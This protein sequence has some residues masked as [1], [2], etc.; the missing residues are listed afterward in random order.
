MIGTSRR[1]C[2]LARM[3]FDVVNTA[4]LIVL[5]SLLSHWLGQRA[6]NG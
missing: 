5:L 3:N 2:A 4:A 1:G 6:A